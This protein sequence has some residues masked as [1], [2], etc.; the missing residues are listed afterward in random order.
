MAHK[1]ILLVID[2]AASDW[3]KTMT[4]DA[5]HDTAY[6]LLTIGFSPAY[7]LH[8]LDEAR[9]DLKKSRVAPLDLNERSQQAEKEVREFY[10]E[11]VRS[12]PH[13]KPGAGVSIKDC[14]AHGNRNLWWY[15]NISE[16][17]IWT[18]RLVHRLF[19]ALRFRLACEMMHFDEIRLRLSDAP[20]CKALAKFGRD[21]HAGT[22]ICRRGRKS[23]NAAT[24]GFLFFGRF[25]YH[26]GCEIVKLLLKRVALCALKLKPTRSGAGGAVGFFSF[27][28]YWWEN[29]DSSKPDNIFF[30]TVTDRIAE[31]NPV[32]HLVWIE[33]WRTLLRNGGQLAGF[34][35]RTDVTVLERLLK[36]RDVLGLFNPHLL[37][38]LWG[39]CR[40]LS[41]LK[42]EFNGI[43]IA[44]FVREELML[45]ATHPHLFQGLL[46]DSA[47]Q[48]LDFSR[49]KALLLRLEFQPFE[50]AVLYNTK[51]R[52]PVVGFQHSILSRNFLNYAFVRG[53][54]GEH[55][56]MRSNSGSMPLPDYIVTTGEL[57]ARY[58]VEAGYP[59]DRVAVG[60]GIRFQK[61]AGATDA[62]TDK[63]TI[64]KR[65]SLPMNRQV[66]LVATSPLFHETQCLLRDLMAFVEEGSRRVHVVVKCHPNAVR[67]PGFLQG[68]NHLLDPSSRH[69]TYEVITHT[70][71]FYDY[72][73][74]ADTV[75]MSGGSI[76]LEAMLLG[77]TPIVYCCP[78][79]FS[80]N[81]LQEHPAV[82]P[83]AWDGPS[84]K[85]AIQKLDD[86]K[87]VQKMQARWPELIR[88]QVSGT[89]S[90]PNVQFV[91][92]LNET[93]HLNV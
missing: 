55:W 23:V 9:I 52:T 75:I 57:G 25:Y 7:A 21:R 39:V 28:P 60:G 88:D 40:S 59:P 24:N 11:L 2:D 68:I 47:L 29:T 67:M 66:I 34:L 61:I 26:L 14:L 82:V 38:K 19:A 27:F 32:C 6:Y 53:E 89:A 22:V 73:R 70:D 62:K 12:L 50:R 13:K 36:P 72:V 69:A 16:K 92:V 77:V 42:L 18:D 45:S 15:L 43:S 58:M 87:A 86:P 1:R 56:R 80:H 3:Y 76:G 90:D 65:C 30:G 49:M 4:A 64:R 85:E 33:P 17:N 54:I 10:L 35:R 31:K 48:K 41:A 79:Q 74:A 44:A 51:N 63:E 5:C 71:R 83:L 91:N 8:R 20:L 37:Q 93:F 81:P 78:T 46:L 84:L